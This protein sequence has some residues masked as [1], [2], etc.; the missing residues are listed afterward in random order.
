MSTYR[1][2][3][4]LA[5]AAENGQL[6]PIPRT[7]LHGQDAT[8]QARALLMQATGASTHQ[9]AAHLA[10]GRP[11]LGEHRDTRQWRVRATPDLDAALTATASRQGITPSEAIR[12][13][14]AAYIN[15]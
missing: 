8:E 9:E 2:Y 12:R 3:D 6:T 10:L 1:T 7:T 11:R 14:V 15:A 4:D 13:A 5:T